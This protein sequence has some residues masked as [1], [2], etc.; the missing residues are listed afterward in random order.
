M[1]YTIHLLFVYVTS[2]FPLH[3]L[4]LYRHKN[5][6]IVFAKCKQLQVPQ[7]EKTCLLTCAPS[8]DS[9]QPVQSDQSSLS[10]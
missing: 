9:N 1:F 5:L 8:K 6:M 4:Y 3:I 2:L 7:R 10:A